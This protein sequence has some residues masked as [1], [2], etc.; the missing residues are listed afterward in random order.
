MTDIHI[1]QPNT[2]FNP[3]FNPSQIDLDSTG[4]YA[5]HDKR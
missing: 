4:L 2:S 1:N 5:F 3:S